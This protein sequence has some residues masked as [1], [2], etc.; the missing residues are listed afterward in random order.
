ML[1]YLSLLFAQAD[2][3][4]PIP[5]P[6]AND[7]FGLD[8][9]QRFVL[10]ILVIACS[11]G[12]ILGIA[13]IASGL[14]ATLHRRRLEIELKQDLLDRGMTAEEIVEVI[15]AAPINDAASRWVEAWQQRKKTGT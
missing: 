11:T 3:P 8:Q 10:L 13:A 15:K 9:E 7:F 1:P 4:S 2:V 14:Y 5:D 12:L 6:W